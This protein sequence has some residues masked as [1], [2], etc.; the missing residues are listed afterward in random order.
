MITIDIRPIRMLMSV[1]LVHRTLQ[2]CEL[3]LAA[4]RLAR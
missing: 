1:R 2:G 3:T 4:T